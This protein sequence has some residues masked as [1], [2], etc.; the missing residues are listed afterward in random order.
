LSTESDQ[1]HLKERK[2]QTS[3]KSSSDLEGDDTTTTALLIGC[4]QVLVLFGISQVAGGM[5]LPAI[6]SIGVVEL[7]IYFVWQEHTTSASRERH[8]ALHLTRGEIP[9]FDDDRTSDDATVRG[10]THKT[11]V[12]PA[13]EA[14]PITR[15]YYGAFAVVIL[16]VF[17]GGF[18]IIG[19][20]T[21]FIDLPNAIM[22][23]VMTAFSF[24]PAWWIH[25]K[26]DRRTFDILKNNRSTRR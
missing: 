3:G 17:A 23:L 8:A 11:V 15:E 4:A 26:L 24:A 16:T 2:R 19:L 7:I 21:L 5:L 12:G 20:I 1:G 9:D 13:A 25:K 22:S 18:G 10:S 14:P 6:V